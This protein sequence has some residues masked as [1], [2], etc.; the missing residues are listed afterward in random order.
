MRHQG[1]CLAALKKSA[2]E[3]KWVNI[4][5]ELPV[6]PIRSRSLQHSEKRKFHGLP[7]RASQHRLPTPAWKE[8]PAEPMRST[9]ICHTTV[10][11][12]CCV[13]K[14]A[15]CATPSGLRKRW[16]WGQC[17]SLHPVSLQSPRN[18]GPASCL[19]YSWGRTMSSYQPQLHMLSSMTK[20]RY[21]PD[22]LQRPLPTQIITLN[23]VIQEE[24][25]YNK[26][27][28]I[29]S[30]RRAQIIESAKVSLAQQKHPLANSP[31]ITIF[32]AGSGS[33]LR[34]H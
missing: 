5:W 9:H 11:F 22:V 17:Q 15:P 16:D 12:L 7:W 33:Q 6:I 29:G 26:A 25:P 24:L 30:L 3:I 23:T 2:V 10:S 18:Q 14:T 4:I 1:T 19:L 31:R 21:G 32:H 27:Q 13:I 34:S 28:K 8:A 20:A